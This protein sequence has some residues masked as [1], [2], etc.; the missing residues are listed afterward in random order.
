MSKLAINGGTPVR[1]KPFPAYVTVGTEEKEAVNRVIDSGVLSRYLGAWHEQFMGGPEVQAL[2]SEWAAYYG[3]KHA[4]AVNSNTSGLICA[5]GATGIGPGDEVIV[6]P[7]S[8]CISATAPLFYGAIPVFADIEPDY[9][10]LDPDDIERKITSK[11]KAILVVD[12]FGQPY[13]AERINELANKHGL[14]VIE[15]AAQAPGASFNGKPTGTL[16]HMGIFSLNY[17][18]HIHC[19]EGGVIVTNDDKLAERLCLIRNHAEAVVE[20]KGVTNLVNML[21]FNFRMTELDASVARCQLQKLSKLN[22][23]RLEN[24]AYLEEGLK[25]IPFLKMPKIREKS[26]HV[27]Y[28]H[29]CRYDKKAA[30][31]PAARFVEALKAE[32]PHF[33]LREKEGT[34]LGSGYVR[35]LYMQPIFQQKIAIGSSG[36]PFTYDSDHTYTQGLCTVC[37]N[38]N[39][40]G[41]LTHEFMLPSMEKRDLDDVLEAFNKVWDGRND[42]R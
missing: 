6:T 24:V 32:L 36:W 10:C 28:I 11:T 1:T 2:E 41:I 4:V 3:M 14:I 16:G 29:V 22:Q 30:G 40:G 20:G 7:W 9:F 5:I 13:D 38:L 18:K 35:P 21:G 42:I 26:S 39:N 31:I 27:Y 12:L 19:G 15:D 25:N 37:E 33:K 34:K 23:K 17:H 8:M